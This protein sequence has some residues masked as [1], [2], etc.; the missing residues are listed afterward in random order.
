MTRLPP[1]V[2]A[3]FERLLA[4]PPA[5]TFDF[6]ITVGQLQRAV[7]HG[8]LCRDGVTEAL[9][10]AKLTRAKAGTVI[11]LPAALDAGLSV[12]QIM[13]A[14]ALLGEAA[15]PALRLFAADCAE[16]VLPLYERDYPDDPRPRK[17]I[18]AARGCALGVVTAQDLAAA[19]A[20]ARDAAWDAAWA[21][22]G[23]TARDAARD[24]A[25]AAAMA[26]AGATAWAAARAAARDAAWD[27]CA[28]LLRRYHHAQSG[29][30]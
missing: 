20:A 27:A 1:A 19:M 12:G 30:L 7:S 26:A 22:A 17:A 23:A 25:W 14:C 5:L 18:E 13:W 8:V 16:M 6:S 29:G 21:A 24:A 28:Q 15:A 2:Q 9:E 4:T 3:E 10:T 11:T